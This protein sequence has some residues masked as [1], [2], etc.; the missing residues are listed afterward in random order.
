LL[1]NPIAI[2]K[3]LAEM[4]RLLH[5]LMNWPDLHSGISVSKH[6]YF[7]NHAAFSCKK[8]GRGIGPIMFVTQSFDKLRSRMRN[9]D[10]AAT[11]PALRRCVSTKQLFPDKRAF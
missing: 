4:K 2:R 10:F 11:L 6:S 7:S 8:I 9:L 5:F 1:H 3:L